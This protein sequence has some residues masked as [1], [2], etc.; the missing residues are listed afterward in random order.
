MLPGGMFTRVSPVVCG[1]DFSDES[2][3]ALAR[4]TDL[5]RLIKAPLHVVTAVEPLLR[6]AA[7]LR[8][9][10][11]DFLSH[12]EQELRGFDAG[13]APAAQTTYE[14]AT[15]VAAEALLAAAAAREAD[16]I[17]VG[18]RGHGRAAR[19]F[20]GS[21]TLRL[22]RGADRPVLAV[23]M[24]AGAAPAAWPSGG[25]MRL[26]CG[27]DFSDASLVA[28]AAARTLAVRLG[29]RLTFV[30]ALAGIDIP[31]GWEALLTEAA[32]GRK[33]DATARLTDLARHGSPEADVKISAG[34]VAES[35][36]AEAAGTPGAVIVVGLVG[37]GH[38]RPGTTAMRVLSASSVPVLGIA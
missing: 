1:V 3:L 14:V 29:A 33:S 9:Q 24:P 13:V 15:G 10:S 6:E 19:L 34:P 8:G 18:T 32:E 37:A 23:P 22:L 12:V 38:H 31:V 4:A 35:L 28:T 7:H 17:V 26:V 25:A 11:A 16:A 2:R 36:V 20:L 21:T 30:H 5:A 27:V